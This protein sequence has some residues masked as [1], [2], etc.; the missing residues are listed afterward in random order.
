MRV[1]LPVRIFLL[2]LVWTVVFT[3]GLGWVVIRDVQET[4][5]TYAETWRQEV[6]T[7]PV[8]SV[9]QP[10]AAEIARR[11]LDP[12]GSELPEEVREV[13]QREISRAMREFIEDLEF[14]DEVF[15][16]DRELR[17]RY[18]SDLEWIDLA[19]RKP[20]FREMFAGTGPLQ[21]TMGEGDE[22]RTWFVVP[23][24]DREEPRGRLGSVLVVYRNDVAVTMK[25]GVRPPSVEDIDVTVPLVLFVIWIAVASIVVAAFS[26]APV[27]R[28]ERA[29]EEFRKR[30]FRGKVDA[31]R[32]GEK[33][34]LAAT[35]RAI[36][37][38]GGELEA[39]DRR[40]REREVLL[41]TLSKALEDGMIALGSDGA[42]K[43]WNRAAL[44]I[45][46]ATDGGA[47]AGA[48]PENAVAA[49]EAALERNPRLARLGDAR[50][51]AAREIELWLADG[52]RAPA[53]V[54]CLPFETGPGEFGRLILIRDLAA[55]RRVEIHLLESSRYAVL[56]HLAAGLAHEIRNPLHSI[57]INAGVVEQYVDREWDDRTRAAM[58]ESLGSIQDET[59]R[60]TD[61]LNN[62]LGM[63]R[64]DQVPA[65][66][67]VRELTR[68]VLQL[69]TYTSGRSGVRLRLEGDDDLPL[70]RGSA[71]R[72][73]QAILNLVL[74]AIQ[75][76][77]DGGEVVLE[78]RA[79]VGAVLV[80]ISDTGP[81]VPERLRDQLFNLRVTTKPG[82]SGLG[83]PLVRLIAETHGGSIRYDERDGGG[84][85]FTLSL[86]AREAA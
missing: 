40:G 44:R 7:F 78:T 84:S 29:I 67:D 18:G 5:A 76:M 17:I 24:F 41:A 43:T 57:G 10:M 74:N 15:V 85:T 58:S 71:D 62:Y 35:V 36:N 8:A 75:A 53:K 49:V 6:A 42:P 61:L 66:V 1:S 68:R 13:Q 50:Q 20:E 16:L 69:L 38:L 72:L 11:L 54:H 63:L 14:V 39:L 32:A 46:T 83:L 19:F 82:G 30:G 48:V 55:L 2:H 73:Q 86:P 52:T 23:V 70:V 47:K 77:P 25:L 64:P 60:L 59:R 9:L 45:L 27:R 4:Y 80:R 65:P 31:G 12:E 81:G 28:L 56:A 79:A 37:E 34:E 33:G 22:M 3:L 51:A 21:K 26:A